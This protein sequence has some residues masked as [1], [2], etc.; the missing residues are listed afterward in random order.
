MK[1]YTCIFNKQNSTRLCSSFSRQTEND[2]FV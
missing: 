1:K 2:Q